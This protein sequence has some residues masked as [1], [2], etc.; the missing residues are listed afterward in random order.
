MYAFNWF[1]R[2]MSRLRHNDQHFLLFLENFPVLS[3]MISE[4]SRTHPATKLYFSPARAGVI[5]QPD[6]RSLLPSIIDIDTHLFY[7]FY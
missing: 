6:F 7:L 1:V 5:N 4:D 2:T 3:N